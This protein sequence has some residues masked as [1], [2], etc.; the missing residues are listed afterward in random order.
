M[1]MH[2]L[3]VSQSALFVSFDLTSREPLKRYFNMRL[4]GFPF[5]RHL[6]SNQAITGFNTVW[7]W[8]SSLIGRYLALVLVLRHS[9]ENR[10]INLNLKIRKVLLSK[11]QVSNALRYS[12]RR[13]QRRVSC[14][15][16]IIIQALMRWK[17]SLPFLYEQRVYGNYGGDLWWITVPLS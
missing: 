11:N 12:K 10:S 8:L 1:H 14:V 3:Y 17:V 5:W 13:N 15:E 6:K 2:S 9:V 4:S 16:T 7:D